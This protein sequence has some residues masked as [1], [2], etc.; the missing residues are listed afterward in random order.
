[1]AKQK[2]AQQTIQQKKPEK[3]CIVGCS[4]SK[5]QTPFDK[6]DEYEFWGVNNLCLTL[7]G[8]WTRWFEIHHISQKDG[9]WLR[10]GKPDFRGQSVKDYLEVLAK[11][12][13]PVYM[14]QPCLL[15]PNAIPYPKDQIV[16]MFGNYF[17]NTISWMIA[18]GIAEKFKE[19]RIYGVDMAVDTEYHHQRPSCEFFMGLA[20]GA[21]INIYVPDSCDLLKARFLYGF[22]EPQETAWSTKMSE[23]INVLE[24]KRSQAEKEKLF[25]QKQEDQ[26]I[27][28]IQAI[29]DMYKVWKGVSGG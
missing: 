28:A 19:I 20:R 10:R 5:T 18:L 24:E 6:P 1:M 22:D 13:C 15:V 21:G 2:K 25:R 12:P 8:P 7:Q 14:Q 29:R 3:V 9:Q 11:L 17:T 27:G 23:T 4:H 26:Y 16:Q